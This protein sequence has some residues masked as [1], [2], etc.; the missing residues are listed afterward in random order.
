MKT[1]IYA[2]F[3]AATPLDAEVRAAMEPY[4]SDQFFNA[5]SVYLASR[6]V[7]A[8]IERSKAEIAHWLGARPAEI[9]MT[10]GATEANNLAIHGLS[11]GEGHIVVS[12]IE[13]EAVLE[14]ARA[15]NHSLAPVDGNGMVKLDELESLIRDD[16]VAV[17][18]M[19][20]NNE[21][22]SVQHLR[23][24]SNLIA[25]VRTARADA[26]NETPIY[27]HT[28]AS[29]APNYLDLHVDKLG[30]DLMT[31]NG[32]KMYGPKQVGVLY[33]RAGIR[34][35]PLIL[36]GGQE[37]GIRSGTENTAGIVGM[38]AALD[39]AQRMRKTEGE[40][41]ELLRSM[42]INGLSEAVNDAEILGHKKQ[43]V[44][45][46]VSVMIPS[47]DGERVVMMLDEAGIMA[48]TGSACG[49][50]R[51]ESS[52]VI[53]ALGF[54]DN[55]ARSTLRFSFGRNSDESHVAAILEVLPNI[56]TESRRMRQL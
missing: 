30:V 22:G 24:I 39:K 50:L 2:D 21:I 56:I 52:H 31:L 49:A 19:Y 18:I 36:G 23:S 14:P 48:A 46:I 47:I 8:V 51:D 9:F 12:S 29:Q 28:D 15:R 10:A 16:T 1:P 55:E 40:R 35:A 6:E 33:V 25:D 53:K 38:A 54:S 27:L 11:G 7:R 3:A 13:H 45:N 34:L 44:P 17:S 26:N 32:G 5:S 43:R 20:A 37:Q 41:L 4:L 42:L